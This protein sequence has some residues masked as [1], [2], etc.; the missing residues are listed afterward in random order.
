MNRKKIISLLLI[1][2]FSFL[3]SWIK[4]GIYEAAYC[5][6]IEKLKLYI[7]EGVNLNEKDYDGDLP[8]NL[9]ASYNQFAAVKLLLKN[10]ANANGRSGYSRTALMNADSLDIIGLLFKYGADISLKDQAGNN[11]L[12][13]ASIRANSPKA[14]ILLKNGMDINSI[15]NLGQTPIIKAILYEYT[16]EQKKRNYIKLLL[17]K[18]ANVNLRDNNNKTAF[19]ISKENGYNTISELLLQHGA[20]E[21][22]Y[23]L[24]PKSLITALINNEYDRA[25]EM[26]NNNIEINFIQGDFSPLM[27]SI[28]NIEIMKLLLEKGADVNLKN[29][30]N[31]TAL[32]IAVISNKQNAV[33]ILLENN[34]D[35]NVVS[36]LND[37]TPLMFALQNK[38]LPIIKM[39]K[40]KDV[41]IH[42]KDSYGN[43]ALMNAIT[44]NSVN[45]KEVKFLI[46]NTDQI[47]MFNNLGMSPLFKA[48]GLDHI[49]LV[50][51]LLKNGA[52]IHLK[53][54]RGV[55]VLDVAKKTKNNPEMI[56]LLND[57]GAKE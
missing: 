43:T 19:I 24:D 41:D 57:F 50:K 6:E 34:A 45:M 31:M 18:K 37:Q 30:S 22:N 29:K 15:N 10:G 2:Y 16:S 51:Y 8:L 36:N 54:Y 3:F 9:A 35:V 7:K 53:N 20:T 28:N 47:N 12:L 17:D 56:K 46:A 49:D 1:L 39:L 26:I 11:A 38:N 27:C 13:L 32:T 21:E 5:G 4:E 14:K 52:D 23:K 48:I 33:K 55:T 25:K 44:L 42:A 40:E